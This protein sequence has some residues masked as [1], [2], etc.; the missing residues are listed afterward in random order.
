VLAVAAGA[1]VVAVVGGVL[2]LNAP[3]RDDPSARTKEL[4]ADERALAALVPEGLRKTCVR[5][6][7][8]LADATASVTCERGP[9]SVTY[10][11][12]AQTADMQRRFDAFSAAVIVP[13]GDCA[14][15]PAASHGYTTNGSPKGEV[16][17][18][19]EDRRSGLSAAS[20]VI[21]WTDEELGVLA[22]GVRGDAADLTLYEWWRMEAG[23]SSNPVL[24]EKDGEAK[25]LEGF[26]ELEIERGD[27]GVSGVADASWAG[28]WTLKLS[29]EEGFAGM[30]TYEQDGELLFGKPN[31]LIFDYGSPFPGFGATCPAYQ[32][33]TWQIRGNHAVFG[34]P[35]GHCRERNLDVL[36]FAPWKRI[37]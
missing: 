21:V 28:A 7:V 12:F 3:G 18:Y 6:D 31:L 15:D 5:A 10:S 26:F 23:P 2:F 33:V 14:N 16:T 34:H 32:S 24:L 4:T 1:L 30:P 35:E 8:L 11:R 29:P 20:S 36:T 22:R 13:G 25:L 9:Y 27:R 19:V 17:C 37:A